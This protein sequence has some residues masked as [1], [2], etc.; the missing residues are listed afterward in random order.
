MHTCDIP[1]PPILLTP[2]HI[3]TIQD[4]RETV[5]LVMRYLKS[6]ASVRVKPMTT[7]TSEWIMIPSVEPMIAK[8]GTI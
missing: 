4:L 1:R 6:E 3:L 5:K 8:L 7:L 2:P